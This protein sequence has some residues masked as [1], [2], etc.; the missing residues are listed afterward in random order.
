VPH[1]D[2]LL[3]NRDSPFHL[4]KSVDDSN[5][6]DRDSYLHTPS[7]VAVVARLQSE[8]GTRSVVILHLSSLSFINTMATTA[9]DSFQQ[10]VAA[11]NALHNA[12]SNSAKKEASLWL[13]DFQEKVITATEACLFSYN[14][15]QLWHS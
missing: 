6:R 15:F 8:N 4:I 10:A 1:V 5:T 9:A 11:I 14:G 13:E 12:P 2:S 3:K 7:R